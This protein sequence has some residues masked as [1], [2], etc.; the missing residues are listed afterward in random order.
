ML[1]SLRVVSR[2]L[3]ALSLLVM[4]SSA[5]AD[6]EPKKIPNIIPPRAEVQTFEHYN[7][8][9][10][11]RFNSLKFTGV[12][13][14]VSRPFAE[15]EP[16]SLVV[17]NGDIG[18]DDV[19]AIKTQIARYLPS[20]VS[21]LVLAWN[22]VSKRLAEESFGRFIDP[23]R[24]QVDVHEGSNSTGAF[25]FRDSGPIPLWGLTDSRDLT[26]AAMDVRNWHGYE[27][28]SWFSPL[29]DAI[30]I[31]PKPSNWLSFQGGNFMADTKGNCFAIVGQMYEQYFSYFYGC[32]TLTA[33]PYAH[34][35]GHVDEVA[36]LLS[37]DLVVTDVP[38][39]VPIFEAMGYA[40]RL[41]PRPEMSYG[42]YINSL[43]V[44]GTVFLPI[45]QEATDQEV[46]K[47]YESAGFKV[48]P[49]DSR[50]LSSTGH[51][52]IHCITMSYPK[53]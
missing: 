18:S 38:E 47:V 22:D 24:F 51:G 10:I 25:W 17:F 44:N 46:I 32:K 52:T 21:L 7:E 15:Y 45:Y 43:I 39:Y 37:D 1:V 4:G 2:G 49:L 53:I 36:K 31:D 26:R 40:V 29:I 5:W 42:T 14:H 13:P 16:T 35:I 50:R 30:Y 48:V 20:D 28:D 23:H 41:L 8:S 6:S 19:R 34:G 33:L 27:P 11:E 12:H 9:L 3:F